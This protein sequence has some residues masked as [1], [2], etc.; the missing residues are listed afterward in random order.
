MN[1]KLGLLFGFCLVVNCMFGQDL[2]RYVFSEP[3]MG[4]SFRI[5]LYADDSTKAEMAVRAAF[6]RIEALNVC[7][8]DYLPESELNLLS[9]KAGTRTWIPVSNDLWTVLHASQIFAKKSK[10]AFDITI[11]PLSRLWRRAMRQ[12]SFPETDKLQEARKAVGYKNLKLNKRRQA[13]RL[14]KPGMKLD[15]GGIAK[16]YAIDEAL[17]V[18][19]SA[20][21]SQALVDGGGDIALGNAP[22]NASGWTVEIPAYSY[23][24]DGKKEI[25][26]MSNCRIAT[27]GDTYKFIELAG[28]RYSHIIDPRTGLGIHER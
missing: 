3:H 10:G 15:L 18:L 28:V 27:S 26:L 8:S 19:Q 7:M 22:P 9:K 11:G 13:V 24:E 21:F 25:V 1:K 23:P 5:I 6:S 14:L 12:A 4:T 2:K 17:K 20:G 16:G